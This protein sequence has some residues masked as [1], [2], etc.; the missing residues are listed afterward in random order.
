[1]AGT[2][3]SR[4]FGIGVALLV[5][6]ALSVGGV[7]SYL[8]TNPF[9][10]SGD[11]VRDQVA[12]GLGS[13]DSEVSTQATDGAIVEKGEVSKGDT[14]E[15]VLNVT[16]TGYGD[17]KSGLVTVTDTLPKYMSYVN[18]S[19]KY[20]STS[21]FKESF[22]SDPKYDSNTRILTIAMAA[23]P[24]NQTASISIQA[25]VD[26]DATSLTAA[27]TKT[28]LLEYV[29]YAN[30]KHG[31]ATVLS[32]GVRHYSGFTQAQKYAVTYQY[33][34]DVP[35][36]ATPPSAVE[37][38]A[39]TQVRVADNPSVLGYNFKGWVIKNGSATITP[40][41]G[42]FTMP[43][44]AVTITGTWEKVVVKEFDISYAWLGQDADVPGDSEIDR[45][46]LEPPTA[47]KVSEGAAVA[48]PKYPAV[49]K[50]EADA[51]AN[52]M[53]K[54]L[55]SDYV[56]KGWKITEGGKV[57]ELTQEEQKAQEFFPKNSVTLTGVWERRSFTVT[58]SFSSPAPTDVAVPSSYTTKWGKTFTPATVNSTQYKFEGWTFTPDLGAQAATY[59]MPK[60]DVSAVGTWSKTYTITVV[61]GT[62]T[63]NKTTAVAGERVKV[64]PVKFTADDPDIEF[65]EWTFENG[66]TQPE[67]WEESGEDRSAEFTMPAKDL[68]IKGN[69]QVSIQF[70]INNGYLSNDEKWS[71]K[72]VPIPMTRQSGAWVGTLNAADIPTGMIPMSSYDGRT[73]KWGDGVTQSQMPSS[74]VGANNIKADITGK[75]VSPASLEFNYYFSAWES[76]TISYEAEDS[77]I[78]VKMN[79]GSSKLS[80]TLHPL[81]GVAVGATATAVSGYHFASWYDKSDEYKFPIWDEANY[82]PQ[83]MQVTGS[84]DVIYQAGTYV[85][86]AEANEYKVRFNTNKGTGTSD[87][88]GEMPDQTFTYD[89]TSTALTKNTYTRD[90]YTFKGW[91]VEAGTNNVRYAD[92][93]LVKNLTNVQDG[94]VNLYAVWQANNYTVKFNGNKGAGSSAINGEMTN[95]SF[96]YDVLQS[97]NQNRFSRTGYNFLGWA[98]EA[99]A[100]EATIKDS[101]KVSTLGKSPNEVVNLYAVWKAK[102]ITLTFDVNKGSGSTNITNSTTGAAITTYG[103]VEGEY[104]QQLTFVNVDGT[105]REGYTFK[106]WGT[107]S[108]QDTAKPSWTS[109]QAVTNPAGL[110]DNA[111]AMNMTIYALWQP[112]TYVVTY[113]KNSTSATGTMATQTLTFDKEEALRDNAFVI[114]ASAFKEWNE[115]Q[116]GNGKGYSNKAV[117]KNIGGNACTNLTLYAQWIESEYTVTYDMNDGVRGQDP[118]ASPAEIQSKVGVKFAD[119]NLIPTTN[120]TRLGYTFSGW[121]KKGTTLKV[122]SSSSYSTLVNGDATVNEVALQATWTESSTKAT[123]KYVSS[124]TSKGTVSRASETVLPVSGSPAGSTATVAGQGYTFKQ[125][126]DEA[127]N[128]VSKN[129]S[130]AP[131]KDATD[132]IYKNAT[133]KAVFEADLVPYKIVYYKQAADGKNYTFDESETR[134][135]TG[136]RTGEA[137]YAVAA[138]AGGAD[139][140]QF[141]GYGL[142]PTKTRYYT[143]AKGETDTVQN[144]A[145]DGSLQIR[146][147]YD[148]NKYNVTF[149]NQGHGIK[150]AS[151]SNLIWGNPVTNPGDLSEPGWTFG[152]WYK[153]S[154]CINEWNFATELM[155]KNNVTIYAK[156]TENTYTVK[157]DAGKGN[158]VGFT[159]KENV[160]WTDANII[161]EATPV[162]VGYK[163]NKWFVNGDTSKRAIGV[164]TTYATAVGYIKGNQDTETITLEADWTREDRDN[165]GTKVNGITVYGNNF[166]MSAADAKAMLERGTNG[167]KTEV[168][169]RSKAF[170]EKE[171]GTPVAID[172]VVQSIKAVQG[173]Y[174]VKIV[175]SGANV[176]VTCTVLDDLQD[177][178]TVMISAKD[179]RISLDEAKELTGEKG[180]LSSTQIFDKYIKYSSAKLWW[181]ETGQE[182]AIIS[183]SIT[184]VTKPAAKGVYNLN[185][186]L[187]TSKKEGSFDKSYNAPLITKKITV[188]D[189]AGS[190]D[191]YRITAQNFSVGIDEVDTLVDSTLIAYANAQAVNTTTGAVETVEVES[192]GIQKKKGVY[193]VVFKTKNNVK[194][195]VNVT[196]KDK[197]V[198]DTSSDYRISANNFTLS[199]ADTKTLTREQV[200]RLANARYYNHAQGGRDIEF[201]QAGSS[202]DFGKIQSIPGTYPVTFSGSG[203]ISVT[204]NAMVVENGSENVG[205]KE[206]IA[207][208]NFSIKKEAV[209][210]ASD[211]DLVKLAG[212]HAYSTETGQSVDVSVKNKDALLAKKGVY[213]LTF[214]TVKGSEVTVKA[215]VVDNSGSGETGGS[216]DD[217]KIVSIA[218]NNFRVSAAD[219]TTKGLSD[220]KSEAGKKNLIALASANAWYVLESAHVKYSIDVATVESSIKPAK[221]VY[222]VKFTSADVDGQT[223]STTIEATVTDSSTDPDTTTEVV[224]ANDFTIGISD[225]E[226]GLTND[227]LIKLANATAYKQQTGEEV[228]ITKVDHNIVAKKGVYNVTFSTAAGNSASVKATVRDSGAE[229]P[230][231]KE[232][233][234]A[235]NFKIKQSN[236]EAALKDDSILVNAASAFAYNVETGVSVAVKVDHSE[237]KTTLKAEKGVYKVTFKTDNGAS[238]E[239]QATVTDNSSS[240]DSGKVDITANNFRAS[241][242]DV[243]DKK[244]NNNTEGKNALV[245]LANAKATNAE[246][247]TDVGIAT[248]DSQIKAEKGAHN[249]SFTSNEVDGEAATISVIATIVD[250]ASTKNNEVLS[251]NNFVI[252]AAD[253][254]GLNDDKV[255][256]L[257]NAYAYNTETG[258]E[259]AITGVDRSKIKATNGIYDVTFSTA[260]N[261]ITVQATV[262]SGGKEDD[263][264]KEYISANNFTISTDQAASGL[265]NHSELI[266]AAGAFAYNTET[267]QSVEVLINTDKTTLKAE[268]GVYDVAFKTAKGTETIVKATVTDKSEPSKP[269]AGKDTALI[270]ANNFRATLDEVRNNELAGASA[271]KDN[272]ISMAN[273]RAWKKSDASSIGIASV[274][275]SIEAKKGSYSVKFTSDAVDGAAAVVDV[276]AQVVDSA[277]VN[278]GVKL[279]ANNFSLNAKEV[280]GLTNEKVIAL[281]NAYAYNESTGAQVAITGVNYSDIKAQRGTY[282]VTF[283]T[284]SN[285][286]TVKA[287]VLDDGTEDSG[288]KERISAN[289]FRI[290][291]ENAAK[292]VAGNNDNILINAAGAVAV[293]TET[294]QSLDIIVDRS[295][296][297]AEKGTYDV[298]FKTNAGTRITVK[299]TVVDSSTPS[300]KDKAV[301]TANNFR[302][303]I[304]D[305][306]N[307]KFN[308]GALSRLKLIEFANAKAYKQS[309]KSSI[310]IDR[311]TSTI[312]ATQK[313][314]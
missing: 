160:R 159:N 196:V 258:K 98:T 255:K 287:T 183:K 138:S 28:E 195:T 89:A 23:I 164:A 219:V 268:K 282:D 173:V 111:E 126:E 151:I 199:V 291:L 52:D 190:D 149:D 275:S 236:V 266:E 9:G 182:A 84:T 75:I 82:V 242:Q 174:S 208:N 122:T 301:V 95:Q 252:G 309:D 155:P 178:G 14:V 203:G 150:P 314:L 64:T 246:L 234:S 261:S 38:A 285:N 220:G 218:A 53:Y 198:N 274:T 59:T 135:I 300:A 3:R 63:T 100:T 284:P 229:K 8:A 302:A 278:S 189:A 171:D 232:Y 130:F 115:R 90:G 58:Y 281:A 165:T 206:Y 158:T 110:P 222:T 147:Y 172:S 253:V 303:S 247:G 88:Q 205:N 152:G 140:K 73:G 167:I 273:A 69:Y 296:F 299:G 125:W 308:D 121:V 39:G 262:R 18:G 312:Q 292:V 197:A 132:H 221:G 269:D 156:W 272:L 193:P 179:F 77:H 35:A 124:D 109:G 120:P 293:N 245:E 22:A 128:V 295:A 85:A 32:N 243:A 184:G 24:A 116:D 181:T 259:V 177:S 44:A 45:P 187:G 146:L 241:L 48:I 211:A 36:G 104:D 216:E 50:T 230:E 240:S 280:A 267:G 43:A 237:G 191:T 129:T 257:A 153:E 297:K 223:A 68:T 133:Y 233:I 264:N 81:N 289:D 254:A 105:Q 102:K 41:G 117:V 91:A 228:A 15:Y 127:G 306:T 65:D 33:A 11:V 143:P 10:Q 225:V 139:A 94:I 283:Q 136:K 265:K 47:G 286:L 107:S 271:N 51:D 227:K 256:F 209:A 201:G 144:V 176:D 106:G 244:L 34:G 5:T 6:L 19:A 61:S 202:V 78:S 311:A 276:N 55:Y 123:I 56:F 101:Q 108:T 249:V 215:T 62:G 97:L 154:G 29:N 270:A 67:D 7:A 131:A 12:L 305:V 290:S 99:S 194:V 307:H 260:N 294:G 166:I 72:E 248:V 145:G 25:K 1:M 251:A 263:V 279:T 118:Q 119:A 226:A 238:V 169:E 16:Y 113:N 298:I 217:K 57:R 162:R 86:H 213:D 186:Q 310:N 207:A 42:Y 180:S 288:S 21:Q 71:Y 31:S 37:Y 26:E 163:F 137:P 20:T 54:S 96:T 87:I 134:V 17:D 112:K 83:K 79:D 313:Q 192:K 157:Y 200:V 13:G 30:V 224:S 168:V 27:G 74:Y 93:A 214:K 76:I 170:A 235:N 2:K 103:T 141:D 304:Q 92:G 250:K 4:F 231:S 204:V 175:A 239:V 70:I 60:S 212:A 210:S 66:S 148:R 80:E 142:T 161:P 46:K 40:S 188:T 49:D 277:N 114:K 185:L